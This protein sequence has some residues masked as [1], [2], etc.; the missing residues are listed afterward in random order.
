MRSVSASSKEAGNAPARTWPRMT[1]LLHGVGPRIS[2]QG[3]AGS[4]GSPAAVATDDG[5][6]A[7]GRQRRYQT[8]IASPRCCIDIVRDVVQEWGRSTV[9]G[10]LR[11]G[12]ISVATRLGH[13]IKQQNVIFQQQQAG[14]FTHNNNNNNKKCVPAPTQSPGHSIP[15]HSGEYYA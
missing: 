14:V 4:G 15:H 12:N 10:N 13:T 8:A 6:I 3:R 7:L 9:D 2:G 11:D 5:C 1:Q